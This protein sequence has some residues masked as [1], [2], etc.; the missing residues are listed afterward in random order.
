MSIFTAPRRSK[1]VLSVIGIACA[2]MLIAHAVPPPPSFTSGNIVVLRMNG[3]SS[4][5]VEVVLDE[6]TTGGT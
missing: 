2:L 1:K 4:S 6:Y 5:A 3:N